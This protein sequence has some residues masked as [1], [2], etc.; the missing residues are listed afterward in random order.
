MVK[1][2]LLKLNNKGFFHLLGSNFL[3]SFLGF[4]TI[5]FLSKFLNP[6]ELGQVKLIQ[7]YGAFFIILGLFGYNL[8][9]LKLCSEKRPN[10][11][12]VKIFALSTKKIFLMSIL[13]SM[14]MILL[15]TFG[16][17][18]QD[19]TVSRW[20]IIYA[21]IIPFAALGYNFTAYLQA[22]KKIKEMAKLQVIVRLQ[23]IFFIFLATYYLG[24]KGLMY[25][26]ILSYIVGTLVY[27]KSTGFGFLKYI[28]IKDR[29][30]KF[31]HY[32]IFTLLGGL[33]TIFG[34]YSDMYLID[35]L[36]SDRE[37][38]GFYSLSTVFFMG[39]VVVIGTVQS[40]ITPHFS[41]NQ[42][43]KVWQKK[44]WIKYQSLAIILAIFVAISMYALTYLLIKYYLG[45]EYNIALD[46]VGIL[47]IKFI[48]WSAYAV[49]G[50]ALAGLGKM[51]Q[52]LYLVVFTVPISIILGYYLYFDFGILG[53]IY[54]QIIANIFVMIIA[55][56]YMR[57][58]VSVNK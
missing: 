45:I 52:G 51:Q 53:V 43:N 42:N 54:G 8:S 38:I 7:A 18:S 27:L 3:I 11:E 31:E 22:L 40:I 25:S 46:Y 29:Y 12:K 33:V 16:L 44:N 39:S 56:I 21:I 26:T 14:A 13:S 10:I 37:L 1:I 35:Y 9:T 20:L 17:L 49:T 6:I 34:Q 2:A 28:N 30:P 57:Q 23:F 47:M 48:V 50:A 41:E 15:S 32:A 55:T 36:E 19:E 4:G 5:I 58:L 24:F